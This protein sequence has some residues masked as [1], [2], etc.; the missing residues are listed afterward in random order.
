[1]FLVVTARYSNREAADMV[2]SVLFLHRNKKMKTTKKNSKKLLEQE[3]VNAFYCYSDELIF[4][5]VILTHTRD[6]TNRT[7]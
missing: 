4:S 7:V 6:Q 3:Y 1:V 5:P 2:Y